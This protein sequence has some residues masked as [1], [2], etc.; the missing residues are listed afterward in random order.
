[1]AANQ[2][3]TRTDARLRA[4]DARRECFDAATPPRQQEHY[5]M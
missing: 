3:T 2:G 1:L 5:G 4:L